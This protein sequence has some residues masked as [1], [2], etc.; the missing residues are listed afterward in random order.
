[1]HESWVNEIGRCLAK[2]MAA[3]SQS[4]GWHHAVVQKDVHSAA[5]NGEL[6]ILKC[7]LQAEQYNMVDID[8]LDD[9]YDPVD[10]GGSEWPRVDL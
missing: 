2:H 9:W 3:P 5:Y 1:M 8:K 10:V 7:L 6:K 4:V